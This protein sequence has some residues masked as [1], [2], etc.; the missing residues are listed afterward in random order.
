MGWSWGR[1]AEERG[2][3]GATMENQ[4]VSA[5]HKR[6]KTSLLEALDTLIRFFLHA[7]RQYK[8]N[9]STQYPNSHQKVVQHNTFKVLFK[10]V[11]KKKKKKKEKEEERNKEN[12]SML[13][14]LILV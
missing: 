4:R 2:L 7:Y 8:N 12:K 14:E 13:T 10:V 11:K 3:H 1:G 9:K 5:V 6:D